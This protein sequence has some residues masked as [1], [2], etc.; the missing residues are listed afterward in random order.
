MNISSHVLDTSIG[1]PAR[2]ISIALRYRS[3]N[4][5]WETLDRQVTDDDGRIGKFS[6]VSHPPGGTYQL[7]FE[8]GEY[9]AASGRQA[10]Y[11]S[12]IIEFEVGSDPHYH[13][14]LLLSPYGYTTYRGS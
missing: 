9:F 8:T 1:Q 11:P 5:E 10:F 13:I 12:V 6:A 2:G 4:G 14:P 7:I 3:L